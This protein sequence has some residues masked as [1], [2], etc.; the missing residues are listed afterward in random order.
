MALGSAFLRVLWF[1]PTS[2]IP[3]VAHA[4]LHLDVVLT[5]RQTGEV[6]ES[7]KSRVFFPPP[8][9]WISLVRKVASLLAFCY[10]IVAMVAFVNRTVLFHVCGSRHVC[11]SVQPHALHVLYIVLSCRLH[12]AECHR[13]FSI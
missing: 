1:R 7:S 4:Y 3:P 13:E 2:V 10:K 8:G 5:G 6:W 9:N 11:I 12:V